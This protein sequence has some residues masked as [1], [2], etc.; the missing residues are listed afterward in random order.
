MYNK[1]NVV[2]AVFLLS[3]IFPVIGFFFTVGTYLCIQPTKL[4]RKFIYFSIVY[5]LAF[6]AYR[7][8]RTNNT[9][10]L[11]R[12]GLSLKIYINSLEINRT[13][14]LMGYSERFY[15]VWF[16]LF[17]IIA[18]LG[19]NIQHLNWLAAFSI[20]SSNL[21]VI[22]NLSNVYESKNADKKVFIKLLLFISF[23]SVFSSYR[24]AWV[25]SLI[26][27]GIFQTT[28]LNKKLFGIIFILLGTGLHPIGLV[29]LFAFIIS[30]FFKFRKYY[31]S[32]FLM[33]GF[34]F[35]IFPGIFRIFF[36]NDFLKAKLLTYIYG[37]WGSYGF[38]ERSEY[39]WFS[40][41]ILLVIL[42]FII[43]YYEMHKDNGENDKIFYKYN[44]FIGW[45]F[46]LSLLLI[47]YRTFANR[48]L[49]NGF[50]LFFPLFYQVFA[51]R[52]IYRNRIISAIALLIWFFMIDIRV[53]NFTNNSYQIGRGFPIN[54]FDSPLF[55]F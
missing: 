31:P 28:V 39:V 21:Y 38:Y 37:K 13:S 52:K 30:T 35:K 6:V 26:A 12:Y 49:I 46:S 17:Y 47:F 9:G 8:V 1:T 34:I 51:N 2:I 40:L 45:Y 14:V 15:P 54:L 29:P 48:L 55:Y 33:I 32:V 16:S 50:L 19:L 20:Y 42:V 5:S 11:V 36:F 41:M 24:T 3:L 7:Y 4:D 10:D 53:F 23:I 22:Y 27:L 43:I 44:N 25:F 18:K